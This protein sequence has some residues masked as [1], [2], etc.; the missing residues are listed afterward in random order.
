MARHGLTD[1]H[2][3]LIEDIFP[4]PAATGRPP[5]KPRDMIDAIL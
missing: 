1:E 2:W 3:E 5:V 4:K